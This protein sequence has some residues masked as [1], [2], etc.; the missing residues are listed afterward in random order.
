[1]LIIVKRFVAR[2]RLRAR[3]EMPPRFEV[4][5]FRRCRERLQSRHGA[6]ETGGRAGMVAVADFRSVADMSRRIALDLWRVPEAIDLVV[7]VPQSGGLPAAFLGLQIG[8]PVVDLEWFAGSTDGDGRED[9][10][11]MHVLLVDDICRTGATMAAARARLAKRVPQTT[12]TTLAVYCQRGAGDRVDIAFE[13]ADTE[14]LLEWSLFRSPVMARAC[15]DM[16]GILCGDATVEQDDDG[17]NYLGF[18]AGTKRHAVPRGRVHRIVTSRLE[19]Y[20]PETEAWLAR[21][22]IEY[23]ELVMLDLPTEAERRRTRPQGRFKADVYRADPEAVLFVESETWQAREIARAVPGKAV[24][25]Y[26]TRTLIDSDN[27]KQSSL[28]RQ[29]RDRLAW[30]VR[31]VAK[32]LGLAR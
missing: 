22:G 20:R 32:R 27:L 6:K 25:D 21:Q 28:K 29:L 3:E 30:Q 16:D 17:P 12:I 14:L 23:G 9:A 13:T 7:A 8:R 5:G 10:R 18:L 11:V 26:R 4:T 19:K 1:M 24:F 2:P 15:L 31:V